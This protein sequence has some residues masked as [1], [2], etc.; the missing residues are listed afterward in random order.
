MPQKITDKL[1]IILGKY[2]P[3]YINTHF[4]HPKEVTQ[5]AKIAC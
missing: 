2:H 4:S 5:A 3:L 1:V